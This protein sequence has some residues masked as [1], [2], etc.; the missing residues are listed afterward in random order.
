[1]KGMLKTSKL[2]ITILVIT[3]V[4]AVLLVVGGAYAKYIKDVPVSGNITVSADLAG[5][6][7]LFEHEAVRDALTGNYTLGENEVVSNSYTLIPGSDVPKDPTIRITDKSAIDAYLYVEIVSTLDGVTFE[8]ADGWTPIS[9]K[10]GRV[11]YVYNTK[12]NSSNM[13]NGE[14]QIINNNLFKVTDQIKFK[15]HQVITFHAYMAQA[16]GTQNAAD[17]FNANF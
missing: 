2:H 9:A 15:A 6:F 4:L 13:P 1:M 8:I 14:I 16:V 12:I 5:S 10:D 17:T 3:A 7:E 11:V